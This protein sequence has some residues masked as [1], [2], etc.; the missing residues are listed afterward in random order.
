MGLITDILV[1]KSKDEILDSLS[2]IYK[3]E[4][5]GEEIDALM[6]L[7]MTVNILKTDQ[8]VGQIAYLDFHETYDNEDLPTIGLSVF[9]KHVQISK[10][11]NSFNKVY[12]EIKEAINKYHMPFAT[13]EIKVNYDDHKVLELSIGLASNSIAAKGRRG[14]ANFCMMNS[15]VLKKLKTVPM[16]TL[17][18]DKL[19]N[20]EIFVGR[21]GA[22]DEP[23]LRL[24]LFEDRYAI[25][26]LGE[27]PECQ[28]VKISF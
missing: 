27:K 19:K 23:G 22:S 17:V 11:I 26:A 7:H 5:S 14:P 9:N 21:K 28:Y 20:N 3:V 16:Q 2:E 10:Y 8:P 24:V 4:R 15:K 12:E 18:D 6:N 13:K 25:V 1:P